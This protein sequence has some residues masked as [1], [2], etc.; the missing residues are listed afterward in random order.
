MMCTPQHA[1]QMPT[2]EGLVAPVTEHAVSRR[3]SAASPIRDCLSCTELLAWGHFPSQSPVTVT[4]GHE[5]LVNLVQFR[6]TLKGH[7][8]PFL[9]VKPHK[10]V[11]VS[12]WARLLPLSNPASIPSHT[13]GWC[14][15]RILI[16]LLHTNSIYVSFLDIP[17]C[18]SNQLDS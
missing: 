16:S 10:A 6:A 18:K 2:S 15:E 11:I 12:T 8:T 3:S 17:S 9:P 5:D 7:L 1:I 14:Q 13:Q 4:W